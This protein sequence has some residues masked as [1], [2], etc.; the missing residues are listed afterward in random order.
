MAI[1]AGDNDTALVGRARQGDKEAFEALYL[2]YRDRIFRLCVNL[3]ADREEAA[4]L[5]QETFINAWK[6]LPKFAGR[7]AFSTWLHR[8]AVNACRQALRRRKIDPPPPQRSAGDP[9]SI[10]AVRA[11]IA[12]LRPNHRTV[13]AL[14]YGEGLS[15][16]EIAES[17]DWPLG[18][19]KATLHR[20]RQAFKEEFC[21]SAGEK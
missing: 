14:R 2:R 10:V 4:D 3:G 21:D 12:S 5:L 11:V 17:L 8:I 1:G 9:A 20:A 13:L 16:R 6:G 7:A 18:R 15:Y 19:V